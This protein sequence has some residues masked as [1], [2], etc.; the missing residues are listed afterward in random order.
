VKIPIEN[1]Y[2]LLCYAW[3]R[4][5][6]AELIDVD[7]EPKTELVDL[8]ARVLG[9][10]VNH[11]LRRG[12]DRG[13]VT[14]EEQVRGVKGKIL[15]SETIAQ[16]PRRTGRTHC[17]YDDLSHDVLTNQII[18]AT[19][20]SLLSIPELDSANKALLFECLS[21]L[22]WVSDVALASNHFRRVQ[23]H[24]NNAFYGF[25]IAVCEIIYENILPSEKDGG[26]RFRDFTRDQS[27]MA[28]LF[29]QFLR[30]FFDREQSKFNVDSPQFRW[31]A[32]GFP[33]DMAL[34]PVMQTDIV[35]TS[36]D[37][38]IVMDAK[39]YVEALQAGQHKTT[40]RSEH[41]YQ[42]YAYLHHLRS[43]RPANT[44]IDGILVYPVVAE[45]LDLKYSI[46]GFGIQIR[47][48]DLDQPWRRLHAATLDLLN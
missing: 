44:T 3:N 39:F 47:T 13:Y 38:S 34:L 17:A 7:I 11:V 27:K 21:R 2:Y 31:R 45:E 29:Q 24:R 9:T 40:V 46:D 48:L 33:K 35:A 5:D 18:K 8:F 14:H 19:I 4:L 22:S 41:L 42:I 37:R 32:S 43:E 26:M 16:L 20:K 1:I 12:L 6:E 28:M 25:L 15:I 10:G 30:N 23:L 36:S